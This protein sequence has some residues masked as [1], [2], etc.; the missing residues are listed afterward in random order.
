MGLF[1][2]QHVNNGSHLVVWWDTMEG[3][4]KLDELESH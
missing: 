1:F 3:E 4:G 2:T